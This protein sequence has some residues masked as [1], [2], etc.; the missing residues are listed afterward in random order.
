[1]AA[2]NPTKAEQ[3]LFDLFCTPLSRSRNNKVGIY[4]RSE[5][6]SFKFKNYN[7]HGYRINAHE[8]SKKVIVAHGFSSG[9]RNF[10]NLAEAIAEA[11][12]E[13]LVFDAPGH[14]KSSGKLINGLLYSEMIIHANKKY[15]PFDHF[16]GHSLGGLAVALVLEQL[17]PDH[18]HKAI[19]IAP[20]T[21]TTS[22]IN[23]AFNVLGLKDEKYHKLLNNAILKYSK[24]PAEWFSI[25]RI[26]PHLRTNN[27]WIHDE[28]DDV[29]PIK[30][31]EPILKKNWPN[32]TTKI[33]Q[34]LGHQKIYKTKE[35]VSLI[36]DF[37]KS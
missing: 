29:T 18:H 23:T 2:L 37:L 13:V 31:A 3:F 5:S 28:D 36:V 33:T 15:G 14:G 19:F 17:N 21:E 22:A 24:H 25:N 8:G 32:L 26:F 9:V 27:L 12:F 7:I 16:I 10:Q 20:A 11:G 6:L 34:G 1:M 30:D 35:I 4:D